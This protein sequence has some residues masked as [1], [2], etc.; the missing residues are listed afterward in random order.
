MRTLP[1]PAE[2]SA[3]KV[4]ATFNNG[5]LEVRLPKTEDAKAKEIKGESRI[6]A[7]LLCY[8]AEEMR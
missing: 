4:K 5:V 1:L 2:V 3:E 8:P 6:A 7:L